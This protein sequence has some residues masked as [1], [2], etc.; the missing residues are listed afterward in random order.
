VSPRAAAIVG[1]SPCGR[2]ITV[3]STVLAEE[4]DTL[5]L[6]RDRTPIELIGAHATLPNG[7]LCAASGT[8][9]TVKDESRGV[10]RR[11]VVTGMTGSGKS[12]FSRALSSKT[13]L[14]LIP[15]DVHYW[16]PG[17]VKPSEEE[18]REKQR[19]LLAGDAWI[20]DGNYHETLELRLERA[21]TVVVL[22]T[23]WWICAS[24]AFARGLRKPDGEMPEGCDDSITRRMRDEWRAVGV[25]WRKRRSEPARERAIIS[26]HGSHVALHVLGSRRAAKEFLSGLNGDESEEA[27]T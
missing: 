14:P 18:W 16:K 1:R 21:E 7:Q 26:Q 27:R 17:W 24:R 2:G 9:R 15:L 13:G 8:L 11:V 4:T 20:A 6:Q 25:I 19:S 23:P 12:T 10:G 3:K 22:D 5:P